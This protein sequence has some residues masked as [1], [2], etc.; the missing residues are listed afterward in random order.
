MCQ[1][2]KWRALTCFPAYLSSYLL[3]CLLSYCTSSHLFR[4]E[5]HD[6]FEE[7]VAVECGDGQV[8]EEAVEHWSRYQLELIDEEQRQT[9]QHVRRDTRHSRLPDTHYPTRCTGKKRS[10][11]TFTTVLIRGR[12]HEIF[13]INP[14][15][16]F[17]VCIFVYL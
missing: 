12:I 13:C 10:N 6:A 8:E 7:L 2:K 5:Q 4:D 14:I 1:L 11:F 17:C 16:D 15:T 9:D 3:T